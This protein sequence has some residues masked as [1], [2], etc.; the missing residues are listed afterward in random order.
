MM[1]DSL[2]IKP[3]LSP[4]GFGAATQGGLFQSVSEAEAH[5]VFQTAW[6]A[7]IRYFDTAPWYGFGQSELRLGEFLRGKHDYVLSSKVGRL[8]REGIP[9]HPSQLDSDG[10]PVF[11]TDTPYNV[12]YDYS[13]DGVMHSFEESLER[14][15]VERIDILFLHDPDVLGLSVKEVMDGGYKALHELREQGLVDAIGAG[16][17]QWQMPLE[18]AQAGEFDLF[19]LAGRY[20]LLDQSSMPFMDHCA[21]QQIGVV[22]GGVYNSGLLANP[23]PGA[24]YD[25]GEAPAEMLQRALRIKAICERFEIDLKAAAI[26]FPQAHPAVTS[27]LTAARSVGQLEQNLAAF[28]QAI[29]L[30]FWRALYQEGLLSETIPTPLEV[31]RD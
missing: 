24:H 14:L 22:V 11:K 1:T 17:N 3:Q 26:Q 21:E 4:L 27:V 2:R 16:M 9:P 31:R 28:R 25:Y 7:G 6:D 19:L 20:T 5:S 18:F 10:T 29:P 23:Q 15:G 12:T 30:E 8:L 13:Y